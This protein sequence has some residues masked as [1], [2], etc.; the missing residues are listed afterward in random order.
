MSKNIR[1]TVKRQRRSWAAKTGAFLIP[2]LLVCGLTMH[3]DS[4][5]DGS[6]KASIQDL[7]LSVEANGV[8]LKQVLDE[9]SARNGILFF[10]HGAAGGEDV[11][12]KLE[13]V[14]LEE[15]LKRLL[16]GYSYVLNP[17]DVAASEDRRQGPRLEVHVLASGR[18]AAGTVATAAGRKSVVSVPKASGSP[19]RGRLNR[20]KTGVAEV[21][22]SPP[23]S[24]VEQ[25]TE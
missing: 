16:R 19:E 1:F 20:R 13:N 14:P 5:A 24:D 2:A 10:S 18:F 15:G 9:L 17:I 7:R 22:L 6:P 21:S 25:E 3:G 23:A 11:S 4:G 8:P 12:I